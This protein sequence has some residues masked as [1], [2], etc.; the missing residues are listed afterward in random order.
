[1]PPGSHTHTHT[2]THRH[3]F[4]F[5]LPVLHTAPHPS[6]SLLSPTHRP[7]HP[8]HTQSP[9]REGHARGPHLACTSHALS[10]HTVPPLLTPSPSSP[11][12]A[13]ATLRAGRQQPAWRAPCPTPAGAPGEEPLAGWDQAPPTSLPHRRLPL[14][15]PCS[16][17]T[18]GHM[19]TR[20]HA[21]PCAPLAAPR[22]QS[23]PHYGPMRLFTHPAG[24]G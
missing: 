5:S 20:S 15:L 18:D 9:P 16:G 21:H 4:S 6:Q 7:P 24:D 23:V 17:Q 22:Q 19:H 11:P 10:T 3:S 1:M 12:D 2:Y 14:F 8:C 13:Q